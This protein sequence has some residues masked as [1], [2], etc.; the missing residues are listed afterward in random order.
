LVVNDKDELES[1]KRLIDLRAYT[2]AQGYQEDKRDSSRGSTC[3]RHPVSN[4]K[5]FIKRDAKTG[6]WIYASVRADRDNGTI[7]DFV[8][9]RQNLSLGALRKELRPWVGQPPVP[10]PGFSP[11]VATTKD[12]HRV[13]TEYARML[14][15]LTHPYLEGERCIPPA[16]LRSD[17]FA[18]RVRSD[19]RGNSV[20]PHFDQEGLCGYEIKNSGFSGFAP[21]GSKGLWLSNVR[22]DDN[23]LVLCESAIDALSFAVIYPDERTRYAS[24]GGKMNPVQPELVRAT[25]ARMPNG[26]EIVAAMDSDAAGAKLAAAVRGAFDLSGRDDLRFAMVEPFGGKDWNEI[27]QR[28]NQAP[29]LS[30]AR[31]SRLDVG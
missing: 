21:G 7:I 19:A 31:V 2:A 28:R 18:G 11:L 24:I 17:R 16:L 25:I 6:H 10:V 29:S 13:E 20:F 4:D 23:R 26:S 1:F 5:I 15:A 14:D 9:S 8:Q 3:M 30:T 27:L 12:R 22:D